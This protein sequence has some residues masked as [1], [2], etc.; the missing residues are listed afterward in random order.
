MSSNLATLPLT[1]EIELNLINNLN[2]YEA[3]LDCTAAPDVASAEHIKLLVPNKNP[4]YIP[5]IKEKGCPSYWVDMKQKL[6]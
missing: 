3:L 2:L 1:D 6:L 5:S 4:Q